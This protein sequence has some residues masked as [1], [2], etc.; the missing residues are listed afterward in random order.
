VLG[1]QSPPLGAQRLTF[2]LS[3]TTGQGAFNAKIATKT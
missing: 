1:V 2:S 3:K